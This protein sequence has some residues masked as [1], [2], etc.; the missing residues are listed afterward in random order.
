MAQQSELSEERSTAL[1]SF[2]QFSGMVC[3]RFDRLAEDTFSR[4][5]ALLPLWGTL[6]GVDAALLE[7]A[8]EALRDP[9]SLHAERLEYNRLFLAPVPLVPL[10]ESL[11][12]SDEK[13]LF[14]EETASVRGWYRR[15]G[16]GILREGY[17][18]EDHLGLELAF[19]GE[20]YDA[21]AREDALLTEL[22]AFASVHMCRW[23]PQCL[24]SLRQHAGT[25]FW[26]GFLSVLV[27][28]ANQLCGELF[29]A[30]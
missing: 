24:E 2:L 12:L 23:V 7:E 1:G 28:L 18:A 9:A 10:W 5:E 20:L 22:E 27:A 4:A 15:F 3:Y 13:L 25:P 21:A 6:P 16:L 30:E 17:E 29:P 11:Y 19:C 14:T 8:F 26:G